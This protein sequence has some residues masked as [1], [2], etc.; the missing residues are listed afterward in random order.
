VS[1]IEAENALM[2]AEEF[3]K[4]MLKLV[5]KRESPTGV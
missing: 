1:K 2:S 3:V 5:Q 4:I